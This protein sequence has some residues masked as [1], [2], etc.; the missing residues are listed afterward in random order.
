M[1]LSVVIKNNDAIYLLCI[2]R[3]HF[4]DTFFHEKQD[5][6]L[7]PDTKYDCV[8]MSNFNYL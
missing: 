8:V 7:T 2:H 1:Q 4:E 5:L 3:S 6:R